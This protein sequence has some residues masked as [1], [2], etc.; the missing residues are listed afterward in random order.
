MEHRGV[1]KDDEE[2]IVGEGA[3]EGFLDLGEVEGVDH[4]AGLRTEGVIFHGGENRL[5]TL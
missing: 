1:L 2:P 4:E 3:I 5:D